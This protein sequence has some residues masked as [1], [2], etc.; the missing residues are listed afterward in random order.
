MSLHDL[1]SLASIKSGV[2]YGAIIFVVLASMIQI[3]KIPI[4]PWDTVLGWIGKKLNSSINK[5]IEAVEKKLD[6]HI[7]ESEAKDIQDARLDILEFANSCMNG[8][9]HTKEQFDFIITMCDKYETHIEEN[10][11]KN[12]VI[13]SAIKEIRRL[14]DKCIQNNSFLKPWEAGGKED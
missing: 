9:K 11:I 6:K 1:L 12:G 13:T 7:K 3:S 5:K 8:R 14:N 10:H 2:S 4:N